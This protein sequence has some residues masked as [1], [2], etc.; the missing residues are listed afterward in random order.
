MTGLLKHPCC[1]FSY[2][3]LSFLIIVKKRKNR[4]QNLRFVKMAGDAYIKET[5][6]SK[7]IHLPIFKM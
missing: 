6:S 2:L 3:P 4:Q 7:V 5:I 1:I